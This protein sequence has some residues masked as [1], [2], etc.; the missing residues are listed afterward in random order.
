MLGTM[1]AVGTLIRDVLKVPK[2]LLL[3]VGTLGPR[4][5]LVLL[6]VV[7]LICWLIG[8]SMILVN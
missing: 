1:L 2:E 4:K 7:S 6:L 8:S 5:W 3:A